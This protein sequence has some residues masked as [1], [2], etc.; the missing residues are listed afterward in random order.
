MLSADLIYQPGFSADPN[1]AQEIKTADWYKQKRN[2]HERMSNEVQ[3]VTE[4][5]E[6]EMLQDHLRE[7]S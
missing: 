1:W 2:T 6:Q 5:N 4:N 7:T 3:I